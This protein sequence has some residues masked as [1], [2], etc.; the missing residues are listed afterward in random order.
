MTPNHLFFIRFSILNHP[1]IGVSP[2]V[3]TP[4]DVFLFRL[5]MWWTFQ[6][7]NARIIEQLQKSKWKPSPEPT[8]WPSPVIDI[9]QPPEISQSMLQYHQISSYHEISQPPEDN[10]LVLEGLFGISLWDVSWDILWMVPHP[11]DVV[12]KKGGSINGIKWRYPQ[13]DGLQW[14]I[15]LKH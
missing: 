3:E 6:W 2:F 5:A 15:P 13:M 14:T 10:P 1:A 9:S 4:H 7:R 8:W 12:W 11:V